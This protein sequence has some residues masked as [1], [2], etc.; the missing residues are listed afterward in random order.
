MLKS[1]QQFKSNIIYKSIQV[2]ILLVIYKSRNYSIHSKQDYYIGGYYNLK[3]FAGWFFN[4]TL[5]LYVTDLPYETVERQAD[6][7][8]EK[9]CK[10]LK[11]YCAAKK[12]EKKWGWPGG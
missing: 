4:R 7:S 8:F 12:N 11:A 2:N 1:I 5:S 3:Y 9:D 10:G 6:K